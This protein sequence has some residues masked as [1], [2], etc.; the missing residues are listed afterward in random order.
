MGFSIVRRN[1]SE[2]WLPVKGSKAGRF[3]DAFSVLRFVDRVISDLK[4]A[5]SAKP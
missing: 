5:P 4:K 3:Y 2:V 1:G